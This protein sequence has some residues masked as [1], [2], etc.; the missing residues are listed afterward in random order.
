IPPIRNGSPAGRSGDRPMDQASYEEPL[1]PT[2]DDPGPPGWGLALL[3]AAEEV[4]LAAFNSPNERFTRV[5][6]N[7][8]EPDLSIQAM[9]ARGL[10]PTVD[11]GYIYGLLPLLVNR[12]W[13]G[14]FGASPAAFRAL[15]LAC[16]LALAW[17]MA[18]FASA[19][20]IGPAGVALVV[21]A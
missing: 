11:F 5:A 15:T 19:L 21:A 9:T 7:D 1:R 3:L 8:S 12:A 16:D 20:R 10:R 17:G 4:A 14:A 13:Y 2:P 6:Y 18:R